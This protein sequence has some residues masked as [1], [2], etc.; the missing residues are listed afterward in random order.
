MKYTKNALF[1]YIIVAVTAN[2]QSS[3]LVRY[4]CDRQPE[5]QFCSQLNNNRVEDDSSRSFVVEGDETTTAPPQQR[6]A[7]QTPQQVADY[8]NTYSAHHDFFCK[9]GGP[10]VG[11]S[12]AVNGDI[13]RAKRFCA[14]YNSACSDKYKETLAAYCLQYTPHFQYYCK[15]PLQV[16][17][18][19]VKFC[20]LFARE[21]HADFAVPL[22]KPTDAP[23]TQTQF[24]TN[25]QPPPAASGNNG[26]QPTPDPA[27]VKQQCDANRALAQ[28]YCFTSVG[29]NPL[30]KPRCDL[31]KQYCV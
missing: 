29:D 28:Q 14:S 19:A 27:Y 4:V 7:G 24:P 1:C 26:G 20:P 31:Y 6:A 23:A 9:N 25:T 21:C 13:E 3:Q 5:L 10:S 12:A 2:A 11:D 30:F 15:N 22:L 18:A 8:C 16:G 17:P